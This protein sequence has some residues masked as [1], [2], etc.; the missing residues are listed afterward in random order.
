MIYLLNTHEY[1]NCIF[2]S[3]SLICIFQLWLYYG[4]ILCFTCFD[5]LIWLTHLFGETFFE[6]LVSYWHPT[7]IVANFIVTFIIQR[8]LAPFIE[9]VCTLVRRRYA[10]KRPVNITNLNL[11]PFKKGVYAILEYSWNKTNI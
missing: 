11:D 7:F 8:K 3:L 4:F 2:Q 5:W 9:T 1:T 6:E 10:R